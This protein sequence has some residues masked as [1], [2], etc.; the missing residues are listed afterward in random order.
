[1]SKTEQNN[2]GEDLTRLPLSESEGTRSH[3]A[4]STVTNALAASENVPEEDKNTAESSETNQ[5]LLSSSSKTKKTTNP[6]RLSRPSEE[7]R[8]KSET[9]DLT[10]PPTSPSRSDPNKIKSFLKK[11]KRR[12]KQADSP[13]SDPSSPT[14]SS[15]IGGHALTGA[16]SPDI[17]SPISG[18]PLSAMR[19]NSEDPSIARISAQSLSSNNGD[20]V[21]IREDQSVGE[22]SSEISDAEFEE[23]RDVFDEKL[24]PPPKFSATEGRSTPVRETVFKEDL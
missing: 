12:S 14:T 21:E 1:M 17:A 6:L 22:D 10:T 7:S 4:R 11:F 8:E 23:T 19:T 18:P 13:S 2:A 24:A 16:R 20:T 5:P 3:P 15:F 9:D